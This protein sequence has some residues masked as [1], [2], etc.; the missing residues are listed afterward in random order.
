[1]NKYMIVYHDGAG[2]L[3]TY[4][5]ESESVDTIVNDVIVNNKYNQFLFDFFEDFLNASLRNGNEFD[6]DEEIDIDEEIEELLSEVH[7]TENLQ[8]LEK[9]IT[10][11]VEDVI[12]VINQQCEE[13]EDPYYSILQFDEQ[14]QQFKYFSYN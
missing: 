7:D 4:I 3:D 13:K 10:K 6:S 1:M 11:S 5:I 14:E 2:S 12:E 8:L 9:Y